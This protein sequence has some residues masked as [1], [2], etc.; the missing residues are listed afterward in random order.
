[1]GRMSAP[2]PPEIWLV[3]HG[4]TEWSKAGRHT[5]RTDVPLTEAGREQAR[6]LR[7]I[8]RGNSFAA[9]YTSP[10]SRARETCTLAGYGDV[11][12]ALDDLREWDYGE[13]EGRTTAA[14]RA[15]HPG[16]TVWSG[17][18]PH[19]ESVE[20]VGARAAAVLERIRNVNGDVALFSHA[21]FLRIF[22]AV[23]L[24]LEPAAGRLF[25]LDTASVS[26]LG[27]ERETRV[28]L[29]WNEDWHRVRTALAA[30]GP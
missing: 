28:I 13:N 10:L 20:D 17:G 5:G 4:E 7:D 18:L 26:R 24:G 25:R 3:R 1:M 16:W 6:A 9:V 27:W 22:A 8:L 23:W 15:E 30:A 19:G 2:F 21:H 12:F 29:T 14:I 11:C